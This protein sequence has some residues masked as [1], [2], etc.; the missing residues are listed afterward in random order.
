MYIQGAIENARLLPKMQAKGYYKDYTCRFYTDKRICANDS[1]FKTVCDLGVDIIPMDA[2]DSYIGLFWR[3][4]PAFDDTV[5]RFIV[6]DTDSRLN[7]RDGAAVREWENTPY[8]FHC[9]RD[10]KRYHRVHIMGGMWGAVKGFMPDF[11]EKME[12]F[13]AS[14]LKSTKDKGLW[15][16]DQ[17]FL[18]RYVW[19]VIVGNHLCHDDYRMVTGKELKYKVFLP[20]KQFVGMQWTAKNKPIIP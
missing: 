9:Q 11:K 10:H 18:Y 13:I 5:D 19:P 14:E 2:C 8:P 17:T 4:K 16:N 15:G 12:K 6:R 1:W 7:S 20:R 3:F